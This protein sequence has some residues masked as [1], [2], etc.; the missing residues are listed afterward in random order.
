MIVGKKWSNGGFEWIFIVG[1]CHKLI[2]IFCLS[3][4][5]I[6]MRWIIGQIRD[7]SGLS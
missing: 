6:V 3:M 2:A 4:L 5:M 7:F 1:W